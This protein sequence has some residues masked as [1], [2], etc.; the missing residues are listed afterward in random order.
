MPISLII[1][2]ASV[3]IYFSFFTRL[4]YNVLFWA[5]TAFLQ[6]WPS[7]WGNAQKMPEAVRM[8]LRIALNLS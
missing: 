1:K 2:E 6:P 3:V 8:A 5:Q 7:C 4:F